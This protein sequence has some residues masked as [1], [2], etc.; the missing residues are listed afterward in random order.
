[1]ASSVLKA[2]A[3]K[4]GPAARKQALTLTEAAAV[5]IRHLLNLRQR[6]YLRL[7]VKARGC[8][9]LSYTLNYA[10]EKGKFDELVEDK[11]V[12]MLVDPKALMHVIGTKMDFV[13]DSLKDVLHFTPRGNR[14][15]FEEV[16][17]KLRDEG[18][19][20]AVDLPFFCS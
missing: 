19:S 3:E 2:V 20:M 1:M 6:P 13:D 4:V 11:G 5:R 14:V 7:G 16:V 18:L 17:E 15:L 8:N 10:D 9:G 12:K